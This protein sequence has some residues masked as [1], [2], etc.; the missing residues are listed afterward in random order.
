MS[1][2]VLV[3]LLAANLLP[4]QS[5][6]N[7]S[8]VWRGTLVN[9]PRRAN[10]PV[11]DVT[12][13]MGPMPVSDN[14]CTTWKTTYSEAGA[15]RQ[16]KDYK[17]CRGA[18]ADDWYVDEGDGVKLTARWLGDVLVSPFRVDNLL[19]VVHTRLT[20]D[21]LV[22]EIITVDDQPKASGV[23]PLRPRS[24]QRL[25]LSRVPPRR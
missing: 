2:A 25:T 19:L 10:A 5:T 12:L 3:L 22:E 1:P 11:V 24:I 20:G 8:G 17:L 16:V 21:M 23:Q 7:F 14:T 4:S 9:E 18:G 15:V 13:E 6:P